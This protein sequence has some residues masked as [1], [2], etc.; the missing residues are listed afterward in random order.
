MQNKE[1]P[2]EGRR[3]V[4]SRAREQASRLSSALRR[5]GADVVEAPAIK[6]EPL[7]DWSALDAAIERVSSYDWIIFTSV[8]GVTPFVERLKILGKNPRELTKVDL[9][10]IGPATR[11][12]LESHGFAVRVVP[13]RYIAEEVFE[14]LR[15]IGPLRG[16]RILLPRADIAREALPDLLRKEGARVDGV[17]AY[18][19]VSA[20]K[21]VGRAVDLVARGQVDVVTLPV[22]LRCEVSFP[23]SMTRR[24]CAT[25]S[26]AP[27]S[28]PSPAELCENKVSH[29]SS[30]PANTLSKVWQ[31]PSLDISSPNRLQMSR[32]VRSHVFSKYTTAPVAQN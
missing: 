16:S 23:P 32:R 20:K 28:A 31:K 1:K 6:I 27:A 13:R 24:L 8:N 7:Q 12:S 25:S 3:V 17:V 4:V 11:S 14:A 19:T 2:L 26:F 18:R 5:L 15:K 21:E 10:A 9:A 30:K 29:P 22:D